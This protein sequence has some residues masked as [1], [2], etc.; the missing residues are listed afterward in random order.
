[1]V[2]V[3]RDIEGFSTRETADMLKIS[4]EATKV[5]LLDAVDAPRA[6]DAAIWGRGDPLAPHSILLNLHSRKAYARR[7]L[8]QLFA[9]V[10]FLLGTID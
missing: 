9:N 3:L 10:D 8:R 4:V 6:V 1:M 2:F 5:R 7:N